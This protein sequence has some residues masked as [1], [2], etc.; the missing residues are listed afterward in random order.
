MNQLPAA[1][2]GRTAASIGR[3]GDQHEKL[4][5]GAGFLPALFGRLVGKVPAHLRDDFVSFVSGLN[6][7]WGS[8][9]SGSE[10]CLCRRLAKKHPGK[11]EIDVDEARCLVN[12]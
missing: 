8:V 11:L 5:W 9:C 12:L 4:E 2:R 3:N 10:S 1:K 7:T 6:L